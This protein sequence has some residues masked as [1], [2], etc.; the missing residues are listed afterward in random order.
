M[1]LLTLKEI[2][3]RTILYRQE[4]ES[5]TSIPVIGEIAYHKPKEHLVIG[6]GKRTFIAEQF[7]SLRTTLP[8][9]GIAKERKKVLVTSTVSGEG[10]SFVVANLGISLGMTGK[11]VVVIEFDLSNPTLSKKLN[12]I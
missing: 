7:R 8:Y 6:E 5:Y 12:V 4:I 2:F 9:R 1:G 10:K 11:R 3:K